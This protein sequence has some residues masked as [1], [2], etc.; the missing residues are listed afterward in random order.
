[1]ALSLISSVRYD[2]ETFILFIHDR[3]LQEQASDGFNCFCSF[4]IDVRL[5]PRIHERSFQE[6]GCSP[7]RLQQNRKARRTLKKRGCLSPFLRRE[8]R[9]LF[10]VVFMNALRHR[11]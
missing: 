11:N 10:V 5:R 7:S 3:M 2:N 9:G 8:R 4:F 6:N 1:M